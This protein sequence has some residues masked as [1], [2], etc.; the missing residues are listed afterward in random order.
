MIDDLG[1]DFIE[2][3]EKLFKKMD[4]IVFLINTEECIVDLLMKLPIRIEIE[5]D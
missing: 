1:L 2:K 4:E 3:N 5:G